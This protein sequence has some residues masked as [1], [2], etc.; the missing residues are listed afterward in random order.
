MFEKGDP[1][2]EK[3]V[4]EGGQNLKKMTKFGFINA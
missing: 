2:Y 4:L 3:K 1:S